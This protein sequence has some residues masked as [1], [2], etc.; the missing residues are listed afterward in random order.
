[1]ESQVEEALVT[2]LEGGESFDYAAVKTLAVPTKPAVPEV[3]IGKPDLQQYDA[4]RA[5]GAQ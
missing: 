1:M 2:L 4:L 3:Q 5:G